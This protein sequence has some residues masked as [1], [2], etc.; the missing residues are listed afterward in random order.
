MCNAMC[1]SVQVRVCLCVRVRRTYILVT[2][3]SSPEGM[4]DYYTLV[5]AVR[6]CVQACM[7]VFVCVCTRE[8][9]AAGCVSNDYLYTPRFGSE[10]CV[11]GHS[12]T[13]TQRLKHPRGTFSLK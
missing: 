13:M 4:A 10:L 3:V 2:E 12:L 7:V 5:P 9:V 6:V 1:V 11:F 8:W